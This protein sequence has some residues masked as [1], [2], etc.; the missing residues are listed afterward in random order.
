MPTHPNLKSAGAASLI[1]YERFRG[2]YSNPLKGKNNNVVEKIA[3]NFS[4]RA[5]RMA[6]Q[7]CV[8]MS[9][10][11]PLTIEKEMTKRLSDAFRHWF[12]TSPTL[13]N[14]R[15][16]YVTGIAGFRFNDVTSLNQKLETNIETGWLADNKISLRLPAINPRQ[17]IIAPARTMSIRLKFISACISINPARST[18]F[19]K[20][21]G[22]GSKNNAVTVISLPYT[23]DLIAANEIE[24]QVSA[25]PG[26]IS[27][28]IG[29]L[30][31]TTL[32]N[33]KLTIV[34]DKKWLPVDIV[35]AAYKK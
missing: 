26:C 30:E 22:F 14:E 13:M 19:I 17:D 21:L 9:Q 3:D 2:L 6:R 29:S 12:A 31:Y 23:K 32:Q 25:Q 5:T 24:L 33:G 28:L 34:A 15:L 8:A 11:S 7:V 27:L 18:Q 10:V 16:N 20:N 4:G 1:F 35:A